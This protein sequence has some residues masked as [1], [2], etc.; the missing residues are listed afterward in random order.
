MHE[1][2]DLEFCTVSI[3][4]NYLIV[5]MNEGIHVTPEYNEILEG[6]VV[7]YFRKTPFVYL[8]WRKNSYS[9]D[10]AIY[11][12]TLQIK[13]LEGFGIITNA[14]GSS[15]KAQIEKQFISIPF[16]IFE[17]IEEAEVWAQHLLQ[18]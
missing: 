12:K 1:E 4:E 11:Q 15:A 2:L 16:Q 7:K 14:I 5:V 6:I 18:S 10:P 9:V 8:T 17:T 13:N 3:Y